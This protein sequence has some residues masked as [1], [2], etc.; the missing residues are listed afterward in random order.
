MQLLVF[1]GRGGSISRGGSRT[2]AVVEQ[3]AARPSR[4]ASC[5]SPSRARRSTTAT[6][7]SRSRCARSSRASTRWRWPSPASGARRV[8]PGWDEAMQLLADASRA[9]YRAFVHD[10]PRFLRVLPGRHAGRRDR[11]HADRLAAAGAGR[12]QRRRHDP[13]GAVDVRV[14]AEPAHA[15]GLVRRRHRPGGG[16]RAATARRWSA[17][18]TGTGRS[19]RG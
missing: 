10:D 1:H 2:E 3:P 13:R 12:R 16:H 6:A 19:S 17:R 14:V 15:A 5:A 7:C 9:R 18:C 8:E 11:A 4:A